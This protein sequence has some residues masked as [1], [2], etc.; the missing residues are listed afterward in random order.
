MSRL[1]RYRPLGRAADTIGSNESKDA[2]KD[3]KPFLFM[4]YSMAYMATNIPVVVG[5][6][7]V[8]HT[9]KAFGI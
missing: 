1:F 4:P 7:S 5:F 6:P 8:K 2:E 3:R 9:K